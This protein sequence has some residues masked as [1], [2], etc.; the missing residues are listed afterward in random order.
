[1]FAWCSVKIEEPEPSPERPPPPPPVKKAPDAPAAKAAPAREPPTPTGLHPVAFL[2]LA[3]PAVQYLRIGL[4]SI[5]DCCLQPVASRLLRWTSFGGMRHSS[6]NACTLR[7]PGS[8]RQDRAQH[9]SAHSNDAL[10]GYN[11]I[12]PAAILTHP[13]AGTP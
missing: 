4:A 10:Q 12:P 11:H 2:L 5:P 7:R 6:L 1:M 8:S 13:S 3:A 9:Q